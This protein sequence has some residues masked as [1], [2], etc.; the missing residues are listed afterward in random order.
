MPMSPSDFFKILIDTPDI[1]KMTDEER[2]KYL[3]D[4]IKKFDKENPDL[5]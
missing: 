3:E 4:K 1:D 2:E 5:I